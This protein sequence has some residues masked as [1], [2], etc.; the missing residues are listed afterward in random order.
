MNVN[1]TRDGSPE[2]A[3]NYCRN[4]KSK[5]VGIRDR[6]W[7]FTTTRK[8]WEYCS[9]EKNDCEINALFH[10]A[11][12]RLHDEKATFFY[13]IEWIVVAVW[14]ITYIWLLLGIGTLHVKADGIFRYLFCELDFFLIKSFFI[15]LF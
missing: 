8:R 14:T 6:P 15:K 11:S 13:P 5:L 7:C 2:E 12:D 1:L 3:K 9:E 4:P 10:E